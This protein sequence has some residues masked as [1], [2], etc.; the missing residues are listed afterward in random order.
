[1]RDRRAGAGQQRRA[2]WSGSRGTTPFGG[3]GGVRRAA[4]C[5][6][7]ELKGVPVFWPDHR[8]Y[9]VRDA[10]G[11]EYGARPPNTFGV[12]EVDEDQV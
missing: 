9:S 11:L 6:D 3:G 4:R 12:V 8:R 7:D 1:M 2:L 5:E 10:K